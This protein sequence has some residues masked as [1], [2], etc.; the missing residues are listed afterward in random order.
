MD[1]NGGDGPGGGGPGGGGGDLADAIASLGGLSALPFGKVLAGLAALPVAYG[2]HVAGGFPL[3]AI[4]TIA[5]GAAALWAAPRARAALAADRFVG[6]LFTLWALS[7]G[8]WFA[9]APPTVFPF[10]GWVGGF[11]MFTLFV[12]LPPMRR[13]AARG[14]LWDDLA[15]G[16]MAIAVVVV[17]ALIAH[18]AA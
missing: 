12:Q 14:P 11:V 6:Q 8:L 1:R 17:S 16:A 3:L 9:G 4:A 5:C 13:L 15:A 10:P 18:G 7:G 2:L